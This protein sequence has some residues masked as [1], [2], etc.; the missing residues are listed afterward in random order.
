MNHEGVKHLMLILYWKPTN[1]SN[2][3]ITVHF[4]FFTGLYYY[5]SMD[6]YAVRRLHR[7]VTY[8]TSIEI[9]RNIASNENPCLP[10]VQYKG[11]TQTAICNTQIWG[12]ESAYVLLAAI[13]VL[14]AYPRCVF[15]P[16]GIPL[17]AN[18]RLVGISFWARMYKFVHKLVTVLNISKLKN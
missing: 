6:S 3:D 10:S 7:R 13:I 11:R 8:K 2:T 14:S 12:L 18:N 1:I 17:S 15:F 5:F 16:P 9:K 4:T